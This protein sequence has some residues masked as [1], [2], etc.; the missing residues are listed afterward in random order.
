MN[1]AASYVLILQN[2]NVSVTI[3]C[4]ALVQKVQAPSLHVNT[5][6]SHHKFRVFYSTDCYFGV[7]PIDRRIVLNSPCP[8]L[9]T[10]ECGFI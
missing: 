10:L 8:T 3:H 5:E 4:H 9:D 2:S 1:V 7:I 6:T